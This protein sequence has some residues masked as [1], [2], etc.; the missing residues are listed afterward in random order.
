M[1]GELAV[2]IGVLGALSVLAVTV[3]MYVR[4]RRLRAE[5]PA[6]AYRR[7]MRAGKSGSR[8]IWAAGSFG[9]VGTG[10]DGWPSSGDSGWGGGGCGSGCG[11]GGGCGGGC[12]G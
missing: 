9:I 8:G 2:A 11:G 3:F 4:V 1:S 6:E 12:G 7:E 10:A 5:S